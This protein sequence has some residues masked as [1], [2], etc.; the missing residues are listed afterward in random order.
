MALIVSPARAQA[1]ARPGPVDSIAD[2]ERLIQQGRRDEAIAG[3]VRL[4]RANF[5][6]SGYLAYLLG[7]LYFEKMQWSNGLAAYDDA[8]RLKPEYR[9]NATLNEN[10]IRALA[11]NQTWRKVNALFV[12]Q[13]RQ[14]GV[15]YLRVA[16]QS[17][18]NPTVRQRAKQILGRVARR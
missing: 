8:L 7:N 5:T 17:D 4:R 14:G 18:K 2:V 1:P 16:A 9:S 13:I 10:A 3:I 11:H 15:K 12:G 6:R